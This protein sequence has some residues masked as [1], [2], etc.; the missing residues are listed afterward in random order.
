M[1]DGA[2]YQQNALDPAGFSQSGVDLDA[3]YGLT[4]RQRVLIVDDDPDTVQLLKQ[5]ISRAGFD[6]ISAMSCQ[7]AVRKCADFPPQM[8]LL[9]L[10]LPKLDGLSVLRRL[11]SGVPERLRDAVYFGEGIAS[12][13][14]TPGS[15]GAQPPGANR[16]SADEGGGLWSLHQHGRM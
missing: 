1:T 4:E 10:M 15:A 12:R 2:F 8:I 7:E 9:D 14:A 6:V 11:R 13:L 5:I 3:I 16:G